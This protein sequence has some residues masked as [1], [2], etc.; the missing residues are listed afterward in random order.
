MRTRII[1][2]VAVAAGTPPSRVSCCS[3]EP[4]V[5][6]RPPGTGINAPA[7]WLVA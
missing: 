5:M 6:P 7:S 3:S 1:A 2:L 4:S